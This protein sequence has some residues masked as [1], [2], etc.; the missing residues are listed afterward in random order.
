MLYNLELTEIFPDDF[1]GNAHKET[2]LEDSAWQAVRENVERLMNAT[3][4]AE[5]TFASNI[6]FEPLV[7]ELLRAQFLMRFA[8]AHNDFLTPSVIGVSA[9]EFNERDL[10]YTKDMMTDFLEDE[11]HGEA[12][13]QVMQG[14][15]A[16]WVPYSVEAAQGLK[17]IWSEPEVQPVSFEDSFA[18]VWS[19]FEGILSDLWPSSNLLPY[20]YLAPQSARLIRVAGRGAVRG[21]P[22]VYGRRFKVRFPD[23]DHFNAAQ[24]VEMPGLR[25]P[26]RSVKRNFISIELPPDLQG[27][28]AAEDFLDNQLQAFE[29]RF[30]AT[31]VED[32]RY[33]LEEGARDVFHP[34]NFGPETTDSPS[35]ED[36][37]DMIRARDAWDDSNGGQDIAIAIVDTGVNGRRPEFPASKQLGGWAPEDDTP[38]TDWHGHGTMCACIAAGTTAAGGAFNGVAPKAGIIACKTNYYDGE[39]TEIYDYLIDLADRGITIV[40]TNSFG[41]QTSV[42]PTP[43]EN[44]DFVDAL[45]D[46]IA[47]GIHVFFSAGNYHHLAGGSPHECAPT[48]I[49]LHKCWADVTTVATCKLDRSMWHYS[50]RGPG[51]HKGEPQMGC[52][53]DVTAPTPQN[54]R[55]V[56]G[57]SIRSMSQGWGTSGAC[58]QVAGLAALLL[59]KDPSLSHGAV[60]HAI[61]DC[62]RPLGYGVNCEGAG[63]IDCKNALEIVK[64]PQAAYR[65]ETAP[66]N[67]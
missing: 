1:D 56:Y 62:A 5:T 26:V 25:V 65:L 52:K 32:Y 46:A 48:S 10:A 31:V 27:D 39:L 28:P 30:N 21:Q 50:S 12:N 33:D 60:R 35:L 4:W 40:A 57:D 64:Q 53:P 18:R 51:Q 22:P 34:S 66:G 37:L 44:S 43:P 3:D 54:G 47:A 45:R 55:V 63:L 42:P 59:A 17:P 8:P 11:T 29:E 19:R 24:A 2:W 23:A 38:W 9:R 16:E 41:N 58:P 7:G 15:L 20:S 13:R 67:L 6:V 36:V 14:W 49:W 61:R